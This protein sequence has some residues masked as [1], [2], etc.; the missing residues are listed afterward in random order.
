MDAAALAAQQQIDDELT[1]LGVNEMDEDGL[2]VA[3]S[4]EG[5][6]V[7]SDAESIETDDAAA[8]EPEGGVED[9]SQEDLD[10]TIAEVESMPGEDAP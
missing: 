4:M 6:P 2:P 3:S 10:A 7:E 1:G 8:L 5:D 9:I